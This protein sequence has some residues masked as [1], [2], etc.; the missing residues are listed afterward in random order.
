VTPAPLSKSNLKVAANCALAKI[1]TTHRFSRTVDDQF[2][3]GFYS[4]HTRFG[5]RLPN[6]K[7][8]LVGAV[9]IEPLSPLITRKLLNLLVAQIVRM[10]RIPTSRY[11]AGTRDRGGL[12]EIQVP[13]CV[14]FIRWR[15]RR[16]G[17]R[18][19]PKQRSPSAYTGTND[20]KFRRF[21]RQFPNQ[22]W[23]TAPVD[24]RTLFC[25]ELLVFIW[26]LSNSL[27]WVSR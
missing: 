1:P 9:G 18:V 19:L 3:P 22:K 13:D 11:T 27:K 24:T 25:V 12:S 23:K 21:A 5:K 26:K 20:V 14:P 2:V 15:S 16:A 4:H 8:G 10:G 17:P 7:D 6:L